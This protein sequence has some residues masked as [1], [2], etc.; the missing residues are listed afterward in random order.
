MSTVTQRLTENSAASQWRQCE[1]MHPE[2]IRVK[3]RASLCM[4]IA[5]LVIV[6]ASHAADA[7]D[8]FGGHL[9]VEGKPYSIYYSSQGE[10]TYVSVF[11][12]WESGLNYSRQTGLVATAVTP[13]SKPLPGL[14]VFNLHGSAPRVAEAAVGRYQ[15]LGLP[16]PNRVICLSCTGGGASVETNASV[17]S[18]C[19][20]GTQTIGLN[21]PNLRLYALPGPGGPY[22]GDIVNLLVTEKNGRLLD[23]ST[24]WQ[25]HEGGSIKSI[26]SFREFGMVGRFRLHFS[27][28]KTLSSE[29]IPGSRT[30]LSASPPSA[31]E[32]ECS[33]P[34]SV[35]PTSPRRILA[36]PRSAN[37]G[38]SIKAAASDMAP[39]LGIAA[40]QTGY[41]YWIAT[42]PAF[43]KDD[44]STC[45]PLEP[46]PLD[47]TN[48]PTVRQLVAHGYEAQAQ[49]DAQ[50]EKNW[51]DPSLPWYTQYYS[52]VIRALMRAG[53]CF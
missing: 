52:L 20:G 3:I 8:Q 37:C 31:P 18:R 4:L 49:I 23:P 15:S 38:R 2:L 21:K 33:A 27:E 44:G 11:D 34:I 25:V 30:A 41:N 22:H 6:D 24:V 36:G 47:Q 13:L 17:I 53:P 40:L 46:L 16:T 51:R 43:V 19:F 45:E 5:T 10:C 32:A 50:L 48:K 14:T 28:R 12:P 1:A 39:A 42:A 9:W 35:Q 7:V 26:W 29:C